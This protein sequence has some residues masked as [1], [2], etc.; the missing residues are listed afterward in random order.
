MQRIGTWALRLLYI[1]AWT[2]FRPINAYIRYRTVPDA[3]LTELAL[4]PTRPVVYVL[5]TRDWSDLFV[6]ERICHDLRLPRPSRTGDHVPDIGRTGVVYM[7]ALLE[8]RR[9]ASSLS[10]LIAAAAAIP[11]YDAQVIPV[12]VFWG[13]DPGS[14]TSLFRLLFADSVQ[15][16]RLRKLFIMLANGRN[17]LASFGRPIS[18]REH[19]DA[20][21]TVPLGQRKLTR[22]LH[23]HFLRARTA[24]LGPTLLPRR[25]VID[26]LL[27]QPVVQAAVDDLCA[28]GRVSRDLA[29]RRAR[30]NAEE[31]AA[32]YSTTVLRFLDKVL[33]AL[34]FKRVFRDID[35]HGLA[36]V[37]DWAHDH[38][39]IYMPCH[40]SHADYLLISYVLYHAGLVPPHIA[41]GV[42]LNFWPVGGLLRRAGAFYMRRSFAGDRLYSSVF[43]A[44]V[45]ALIRRGYPI[46]FFPEGGRSRTGR[47]LA[48]KTGLLSMVVEASLRQRARKVA[49]VPVYIGY[50]RVWE[51]GSYTK[52]LK[53]AAKRKESAEGL[54]KA[55]TILS[56]QYGKA[57]VNFGEPIRLQDAADTA[58]PD[59]RTVLTPNG[60]DKPE[61]FGRF[62]QHLAQETARRI[63]AATVANANGL[64]AVTLLA[65][66]Q[67]AVSHDEFVEQV[68]HL[69]NLIRGLPL[70]QDQ[71]I[72][73][74]SPAEILE[75]AMPIAGIARVHHAWGDIYGITGKSAVAMTYNRNNV[76]H[77]LALPGLVANFFRT[78]GAIPESS[79]IEGVQ[80]LYPFLR[81]EFYLPWAPD[82]VASIA[83]DTVA[84]MITMGL[85]QR[86]PE[87]ATWLCRPPVTAPA[88]ST[89]AMLGRVMGET[90]ER[91]CMITVLLA[92]EAR[93]GETVSRK[94]IETDCRLLAE[95]MALLTGREA[96]EFFDATLFRAHLQ[97]LLSVGLLQKDDGEGLR[98]SDDIHRSAE[99]ALELLSD[100]ARQMLAQLLSRRVPSTPNVQT[101]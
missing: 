63:S 61:G 25:V 77:M 22:A 32:D 1:V 28:D 101:G 95:R 90:L 79:V 57:Y 89:L 93:R 47:M 67:R 97:T 39:L 34:V 5:A 13:R 83:R 78:R 72:T 2:L 33:G 20:V 96:P 92:D 21:A 36:R 31:I 38:E 14:E 59:W 29:L 87:D 50:D 48:P 94:A 6:L 35:V 19:F 82:A 52:E 88:F 4:D 98:I 24:A 7:P 41:A 43:R 91:Y 15:A 66:P 64:A 73:E 3:L 81:A 27:R 68:G 44:Y 17:V 51:V 58:L 46:E 30:K 75:W 76:Q 53:G 71:V 65:A 70:G 56:R 9:K 69:T 54:L 86:D 16:S 11:D 62:V 18:F 74:L 49:I 40:R 12:S 8:E 80:A 84:V 26:E 99:R 45:D 23:F 42:N 85:L 60:H 55:G 37:R 10:E 100:D